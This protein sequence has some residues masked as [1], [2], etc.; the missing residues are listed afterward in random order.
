MKVSMTVSSR[1]YVG[2]NAEA[3][4]FSLCSSE[5]FSC[6]MDIVHRSDSAN[7]CTI[8]SIGDR[9]SGTIFQQG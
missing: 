6:D 5:V 8:G 4:T 2:L 9:R 1:L 3:E 7:R